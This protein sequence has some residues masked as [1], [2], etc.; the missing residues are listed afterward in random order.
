MFLAS[1]SGMFGAILEDT[2][3]AFFHTIKPPK[4]D[5]FLDDLVEALRDRSRRLLGVLGSLFGGP[6]FQIRCKKQYETPGFKNTPLRNLGSLGPLSGVILPHFI[7]FRIPK[8]NPE[9][10]QN[11]SNIAPENELVFEP[12]FD[13][14]SIYL[15]SQNGTQTRNLGPSGK[16][17]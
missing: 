13:N 9:L 6:V 12:I 3:H 11:Q 7:G 1:F 2:F 4:I 15:G 14:F 16:S 17:S 10:L 5:P 8:W